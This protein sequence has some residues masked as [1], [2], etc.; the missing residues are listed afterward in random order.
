VNEYIFY[1][2]NFREYN[3]RYTFRKPDYFSDALSKPYYNAVI[4]TPTKSPTKT[5]LLGG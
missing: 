1:S 2:R 5:N 3:G 4:K